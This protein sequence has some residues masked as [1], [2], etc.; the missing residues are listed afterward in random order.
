MADDKQ[1]QDHKPAVK[2]FGA[3][4]PADGKPADDKPKPDADKPAPDVPSGSETIPGGAYIVDGVVRD[5][6]GEEL[7]GF[8]VG[9]A[10]DGTP[11]IVRK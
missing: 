6:N 4:V 10:D 2:P 11:K 3:G 9:K 1:P 7:K 5:A 8:K